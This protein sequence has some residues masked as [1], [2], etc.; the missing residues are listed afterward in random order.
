MSLVDG[1]M[2][3]TNNSN[4]EASTSSH[5]WTITTKGDTLRIMTDR[6][7]SGPNATGYKGEICWD[8]NYIYVCIANG[9]WK[10]AALSN[11]LWV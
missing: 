4:P 1:P 11:L 3:A 6:T 10:R 5:T 8:D 2:H 7:P 9:S